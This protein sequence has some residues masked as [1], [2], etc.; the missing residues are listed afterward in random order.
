ML[1]STALVKA[2]HDETVFLA[3]ATLWDSL[4]AATIETLPRVVQSVLS[5]SA[6]DGEPQPLR[7]L[8]GFLEESRDIN[9]WTAI[10]TGLGLATLE[11]HV[12]FIHVRALKQHGVQPAHWWLASMYADPQL[13]VPTLPGAE[14]LKSLQDAILGVSR[15]AKAE[16]CE[17][18]VCSISL[19]E[20]PHLA[21]TT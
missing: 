20:D 3:A 1:R 7:H 8:A 6:E 21:A 13:D 15:I 9:Q 5:A 18:P 17:G 11:R 12:A 19:R 4:P 16:T 14:Q 2:S 10:L